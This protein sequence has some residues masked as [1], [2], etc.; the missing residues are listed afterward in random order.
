MLIGRL[1]PVK[2]VQY[3]RFSGI[4]QDLPEVF[5][6]PIWFRPFHSRF[7]QKILRS[8]V[9][10]S[11]SLPYRIRCVHNDAAL[12]KQEVPVLPQPPSNYIW[13]AYR[14][15][16]RLVP[17]L[18]MFPSAVLSLS[19]HLPFLNLLSPPHKPKDKIYY[20]HRYRMYFSILRRQLIPV[21]SIFLTSG[22]E[23]AHIPLICESYMVCF[24]RNP[25]RNHLLS[26]EFFDCETR[27]SHKI[28]KALRVLPHPI[29]R[30]AHRIHFHWSLRESPAS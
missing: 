16:Q 8:P 1:Q 15:R 20:P 9:P 23:V 4:R 29:C 6:H 11:H 12:S 26:H 22:S 17:L 18:T 7:R 27:C 5:L 14:R 28:P 3:F 2:M 13:D 19:M 30:L 25:S 21:L 24:Y 10:S